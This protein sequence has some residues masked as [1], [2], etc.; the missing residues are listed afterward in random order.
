LPEALS[1]A[2]AAGLFN[3][4]I[5]KFAAALPDLSVDALPEGAAGALG[6]ADVPGVASILML[7]ACG[8]VGA[9]VGIPGVAAPGAPAPAAAATPGAPAAA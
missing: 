6:D 4:V 8:M 1:V 3:A 2:S 5:A 7:A 9:E